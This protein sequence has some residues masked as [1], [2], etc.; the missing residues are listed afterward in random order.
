MKKTIWTTLEHLCSRNENSRHDKYPTGTD[1]WCQYRKYEAMGTVE[2]YDHPP[3]LHSNIEKH[4]ISISIYRDLS[5]ENLLTRSLSGH[6][7]NANE[8]FNSTIWRLAPKHLNCGAKII[9]T[10]AF[11]VAGIFNEGYFA[12]LKFMNE[13]EINIGPECK[14]YANMYDTQRISTQERRRT[15]STREA[16]ATRRMAQI[17]QNEFNE[18]AEGLLYGSGI[19]D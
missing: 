16:Q 4:L 2:N 13:L 18:E 11:I 1:S 6:T 14:Q 12:I 19:A 5:N 10:A 15:S 7:Q 8:N 9:E 3:P 17:A